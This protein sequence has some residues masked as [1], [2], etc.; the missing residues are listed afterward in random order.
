MECEICTYTCVISYNNILKTKYQNIN[1]STYRR[2]TLCALGQ[3]VFRRGAWASSKFK[4]Q[5][6]KLAMFLFVFK[7]WFYLYVFVCDD[8]GDPK[9][10]LAEFSAR[11]GFM[12]N[13]RQR[14][15]NIVIGD[16][17]HLEKKP[18]FSLGEFSIY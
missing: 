11:V 2:G 12:A 8:C 5:S 6:S 15:V 10:E 14:G 4:V 18:N 17:C 3:N 7:V 13:R 9:V 1:E 16:S